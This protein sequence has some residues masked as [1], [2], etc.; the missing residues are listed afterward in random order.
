MR[1]VESTRLRKAKNPP[2]PHDH[3]A[4]AHGHEGHG[5]DH[6][7]D[8]APP[9]TAGNER[10]VLLAF[11]LTFAFMGVEV[12][13]G[14]LSGS[15]ALIA[16][17]G[18]MLTDAAALAL[19]YGAFRAGRRPADPRRTFGYLR[20]E[21]VAGLAN[22]AAL[23]ALVGWIA[24]EAFHRL[25]DPQPVLAGPMLAVAVAGL[26]VNLVVLRI[27]SQGDSEHVNIRGAALHVMGDL[28]GSVGAI[29][30]A[31]V[32]HYTGWA[33]ID[34]LLSVLVSLLILRSAWPLLRKSLHILLEGAPDDASPDAIEHHLLATVPGLVAV[35]HV[36]VWLITSGQALATL[37]VKP[38]PHADPRT[39]VRRVEHELVE[40][41]GI[42]HATVAIDWNEDE[43]DPACSLSAAHGPPDRG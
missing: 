12:A 30:A 43:G 5:H 26:L 18:H 17:A 24:W 16:D 21:V 20:F 15:L 25:R 8:H 36:H 32:I 29:V 23:L 28:L 22:A 10:K 3:A 2:M 4:H 40:R 11:L 41:F 6:D 35:S 38:A 31:V 7:H 27:L 14:L 13:G 42:G 33:P 39:L 34:P 1:A 19:A 37:H 9:V